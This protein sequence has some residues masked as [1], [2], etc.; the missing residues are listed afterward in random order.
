MKIKFTCHSCK[1]EIEVQSDIYDKVYKDKEVCLSCR[2]KKGAEQIMDKVTAN[3]NGYMNNNQAQAY[4][5]YALCKLVECG[6]LSAEM[7]PIILREMYI[8]F[9]ML[10]LGEVEERTSK[11]RDTIK[12]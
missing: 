2:S 11:I 7:I 3:R 4:A 10:T 9:D 8:T 12:E 1:K 6:E 5:E